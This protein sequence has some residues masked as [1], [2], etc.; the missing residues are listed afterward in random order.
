MSVTC[1]LFA[2]IPLVTK[3]VIISENLLNKDQKNVKKLISYFKWLIAVF[4]AVFLKAF[5]FC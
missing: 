2:I 3:V 1:L 4:E 5:D